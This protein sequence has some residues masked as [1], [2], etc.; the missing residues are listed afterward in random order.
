MTQLTVSPLSL[1]PVPAGKPWGRSA[2]RWTRTPDDDSQSSGTGSSH[3]DDLTDKTWIL[4]SEKD[5][6][7]HNVNMMSSK[8]KF[9]FL[10]N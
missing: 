7:G 5:L 9:E 10:N 4:Q 2:D 3:S 1:P 6:N 8:V